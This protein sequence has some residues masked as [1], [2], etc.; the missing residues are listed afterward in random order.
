MDLM[1]RLTYRAID[2]WRRHNRNSAKIHK[3]R[4]Y[5]SAA[6]LPEQINRHV[7][8]LAGDPPAWAVMA[9]PCGHG[10]RLQIRIRAHDGAVVWA[11]TESR[12]GPSLRPSVDFESRGVRCHFWLDRGRVRWVK[13]QRG[14]RR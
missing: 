2:W 10:H 9:C 12:S 13:D 14:Q 4:S 5:P 3:I 6:A 11:L 7:L 8:A 1:T